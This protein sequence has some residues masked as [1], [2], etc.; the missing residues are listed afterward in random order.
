VQFLHYTVDVPDGMSVVVS[1]DRAANVQLMDDLNLSRYKRRERYR[2]F[3]G[4]TTASPVVLTPP[5]AGRW[6][7]AVDLGGARGSVRVSV[8]VQ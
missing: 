8:K 6:N 1:L 7:V 4:H 3:G 2:Y 5:H